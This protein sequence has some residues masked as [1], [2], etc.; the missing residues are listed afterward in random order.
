MSTSMSRRGAGLG[1][2]LILCSPLAPPLA[3][4]P[5]VPH[6][7]L[8]LPAVGMVVAEDERVLSRGSG[9]VAGDPRLVFGCAHVLFDEGHWLTD[10]SFAPGWHVM[11]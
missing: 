10:M 5:V 7:E 11:E 2:A 1:L 9:T 3:A 8:L 4:T 6:R